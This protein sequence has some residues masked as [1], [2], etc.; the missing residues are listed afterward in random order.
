MLTPN[1]LGLKTEGTAMDG[2]ALRIAREARGETQQ[3]FADWL[4]ASLAR[5]YDKG[6]I[7]RWE[8]GGERSLRRSSTC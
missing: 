6:R 5:K 3:T 2:A 4:N 8:T 1:I 7:S